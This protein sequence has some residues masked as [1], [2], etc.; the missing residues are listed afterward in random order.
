MKNIIGMAKKNI[1]KGWINIDELNKSI[2]LLQQKNWEKEF[3]K[4][5]TEKSSI[6]G[7]SWRSATPSSDGMPNYNWCKPDEVK[8]FIRS[9]FAGQQKKN[10]VRKIYQYRTG[11]FIPDGSIYLNT[12]VQ[13]QESEGNGIWQS[14]WYIWHCFLL[15]TPED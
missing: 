11:E 1:K 12:V 3:D 15:E 6:V 9:L 2:T 10:T 5:F 14:C 4:R 7:L 13:T 8:S